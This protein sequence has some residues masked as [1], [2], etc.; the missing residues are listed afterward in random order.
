M[1]DATEE[2]L[3]GWGNTAPSLARVERPRTD[4]EVE[5]AFDET[6]GPLI[7]RGLGR[8][9]GDAA[10]CAGGTVISNRGLWHL[11]P[12]DPDTGLVTLGAG[13][14]L[15]ELLAVS[16]PAGYFVP[17]TPGTRQVTIGG[18]IGADIHGKNHHVEGSF[19][20]HVTSMTL[21]TDRKSVV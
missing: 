16:I 5:E 21:A 4:S 10:Q 9:Y 7:P 15:D 17:V 11:S 1:I 6:T 2:L 8:S 19:T 12:I 20:R 14:S 13:V 3:T 18:A